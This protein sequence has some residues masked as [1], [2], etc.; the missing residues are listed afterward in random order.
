MIQADLLEGVL[1]STRLIPCVV[2]GMSSDQ[3]LTSAVL[4]SLLCYS[5]MQWP[6]LMCC[7]SVPAMA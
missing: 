6:N 4:S 2:R 3:G 7:V 1:F 5:A